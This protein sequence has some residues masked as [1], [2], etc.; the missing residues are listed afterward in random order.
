MDD[1]IFVSKPFGDVVGSW[2]DWDASATTTKP[3]FL[4]DL[5]NKSP[6]L[7]E[8]SKTVAKQQKSQAK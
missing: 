7:K 5:T 2:N 1:A 4:K 3:K 6:T 8:L